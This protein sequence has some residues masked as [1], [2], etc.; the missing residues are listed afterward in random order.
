MNL[1]R[2]VVAAFAVC[3]AGAAFAQDKPLR[4][5][6]GFPPGAASDT[7]TRLLADRMRASLG[8]TIIVENRPGAAGIVG[9]ETVKAAI[10]RT[11]YDKWGPVI[12]A[13][14]FKPTQ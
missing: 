14:G 4:I 3:I 8:Q 7:L 6:L 1:H 2:Y 10:L 9:N 13:S 5:V 11:D 12:R